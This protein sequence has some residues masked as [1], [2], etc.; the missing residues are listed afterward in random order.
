MVWVQMVKLF[1]FFFVAA[2]LVIQCITNVGAEVSDIKIIYYIT[3]QRIFGNQRDT[4]IFS[5]I[6]INKINLC[7]KIIRTVIK[8]KLI[9][10]HSNE[11]PLIVRKP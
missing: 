9:F 3:I 7:K 4:H 5:I 6:K 1:Y 8:S 10:V 11:N 2:F